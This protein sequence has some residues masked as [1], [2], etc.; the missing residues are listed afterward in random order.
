MEDRADSGQLAQF[1]R[2]SVITIRRPDLFMAEVRRGQEMHR[3]WH[4]GKEFTILNVRRNEYAVIQTPQRI[5]EMLDFLADKH[6]IVIPLDDLL[7][8]DPYRNLVAHIETGV[9]VDQSDIAGHK[10]DHL[11][12]TQDNVDWQIWIDTGAQAVPRKV[13]ITYK[14]DPDRPQYEAV[15]DDWQLDVAVDASQFAPQI[16]ASAKKVDIKDLRDSE[17]GE[18]K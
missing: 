8:P 18:Q 16:P 13:V 6:G 14:D 10:C 5:E 1:S 7:Y 17:E 11:L 12:F 4:H 2:D 15:L 9:F 3:F